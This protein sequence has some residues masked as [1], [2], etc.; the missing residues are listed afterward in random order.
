MPQK[1]LNETRIQL[2]N[3]L[4]LPASLCGSENWTVRA[5]DARRITAAEMKFMRET[6]VDA[7]TDYKTNTEIAK[8]L[9]ITPDL[10]KMQDYRSNW[11][12]RVGRMSFT[13][14]LG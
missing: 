8:K 6:A 12:R 7:W 1:S 14:Y 13:D 2:N 5:R 9:N 4:R 3:T 11:T 10:D